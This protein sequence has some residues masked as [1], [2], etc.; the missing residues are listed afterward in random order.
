MTFYATNNNGQP[1]TRYRKGRAFVMDDI[2]YPSAVWRESDAE[3][4]ARGLYP[5]IPASGIDKNYYYNADANTWTF[6]NNQ[7]IEGNTPTLK[8]IEILKRKRIDELTRLRITTALG[9]MTVLTK[10]VATDQESQN[11][12][13]IVASALAAGE[14]FPAGGVPFYS[15]EGERVRLNET[16]FQTLVRA[17]ALHLIQCQDV[18]ETHEDALNALITQQ[19]VVDYDITAGFPA[20]PDLTETI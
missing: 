18:F 20:N 16:Q 12:V 3:L 10:P 9:G 5:M 7:F 19:E 1:G 4:A 6:T 2:Q 14:P 11:R 8:S 15:M 17:M 13:N